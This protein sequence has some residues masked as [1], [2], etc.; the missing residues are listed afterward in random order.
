MLLFFLLV[1]SACPF[2]LVG[3]S[4]RWA[5]LR[6][7]KDPVSQAL[8]RKLERIELS[9]ETEAPGVI[10]I[11]ESTAYEPRDG[12]TP[13]AVVHFVGGAG[14]G[15]VPGAAYGYL[16]GAIA[17]AAGVGVVATPYDL[18]LDHYESLRDV[19][20]KFDAALKALKAQRAWEATKV[21]GLGHSLGAKLLL[22]SDDGRYD[23]VVAVA[24]NNM[25][26]ADS[27]KL[28]K[29]FLIALGG[30]DDEAGASSSPTKNKNAALDG[31]FDLV[32]MAAAAAGVDV[33]PSPAETLNRLLGATDVAF[34]AFD[35]DALDST[36]Q[37]AD[38]LP[39]RPD[40]VRLPGGHLSCVYIAAPFAVGSPAAVQDVTDAIA[41]A[42]Q[43]VNPP[44]PPTLLSPAKDDDD[45]DD[46]HT[47]QHR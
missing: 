22:L 31:L 12:R 36:D 9:R 21:F 28:L 38:A 14:L 43:I 45:D 13:W 7:E 40:V 33:V 8:I 16:L 24:A 15:T 46:D 17:D 6:A 27:A 4:P 29:E 3:P 32:G 18:G 19:Q 41:R 34:L 25:G 11:G 44:A 10:D 35:G 23:K 2:V 37:L 47:Q 20:A 30:D 5:P 42:L 39:N 26:V 1:A